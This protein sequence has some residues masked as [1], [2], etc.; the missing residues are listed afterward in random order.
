[1]TATTRRGDDT[2]VGRDRC[3]A[4]TNT[5]RQTLH[6]YFDYFGINAGPAGLGYYSFELGSWLVLALNS[7]TGISAQVNWLKEVVGRARGRCT[8]AYWHHPLF[9]SG[10][11]PKLA[12]IRSW[13]NVL[14]AAN[15]DVVL[16]A[17]DHLY[18]RFAPQDDGG[19]PDPARG[20]RQFVVGTG[21][22]PLHG[23]SGP[24]RNS[25]VRIAAFG[26]LKLTLMSDGYDWEFIA[27]SGERDFGSGR[28][29]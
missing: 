16:S 3:R 27:V 18:E 9:S 6:P 25:E 21:G 13:W 17:H 24:T 12:G 5:S 23:V 29:H 28:C 20:I 14:H 15:A 10:P 19:T 7:N 4:I 1:M 2:G 22:A 26:V 8:L 11:S